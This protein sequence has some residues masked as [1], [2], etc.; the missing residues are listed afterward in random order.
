MEKFKNILK[1]IGSS[2]LALGMTF[3]AIPS[4]TVYG[5]EGNTGRPNTAVVYDA[6]SK[7]NLTMGSHTLQPHKIY[8]CPGSETHNHNGLNG[9][10][11]FNAVY[12]CPLK[13]EMFCIDINKGMPDNKLYKGSPKTP[14]EL[15][16]KVIEFL[17]EHYF[18]KDRTKAEEAFK[19]VGYVQ[20]A[21][22]GFKDKDHPNGN[23]TR[24]MYEATQMLI[25]E[26]GNGAQYESGASSKVKDLYDDIKLR[27][28]NALKTPNF[29]GNKGYNY[30]GNDTGEVELN[31]Y[32][33]E[34]AITLTDSEKVLH[35]FAEGG[36]P[37]IAVNNNKLHLEIEG[38]TCKVWTDKGYT[39]SSGVINVNSRYLYDNRSSAKSGFFY[40]GQDQ[41]QSLIFGGLDPT[42]FVI[43]VKM[44]LAGEA[45]VEKQDKETGEHPQ[46]DT[47]FKGAQFKLYFD[48]NCTD[49]VPN[50]PVIT[51]NEKGKPNK[52]WTELDRTKTYYVKEEKTPAG[53]LLNNEP[54]KLSFELVNG[55]YKASITIKDT[56]IKGKVQVHKY[57]LEEGSGIPVN[58]KGAEFTLYNK[59]NKKVASFTTNDK[60]IGVSPLLPYGSYTMKQTKAPF[61]TEIDTHTYSVVIKNK[62]QT[63]KLEPIV[64]IQQDYTL[65][66]V[67]KD[68]ETGALISYTGAKFQV[69]KDEGKPIDPTKDKP[70]SVKVGSRNY[71]TFITKNSTSASGTNAEFFGT[72]EEAGTVITPLKLQAGK[73]IL[74]EIEA[75][76]GFRD[77]SKET[78]SFIPFIVGEGLLTEDK[79]GNALITVEVKD[80]Q[81]KQRIA[82]KKTIEQKTNKVYDLS[83]IEYEIVARNDVVDFLTGA[84]IARAGEVVQT[85]KGELITSETQDKYKDI[86]IGNVPADKPTLL[87]VSDYLAEGEYTLRETKTCEGLVLDKTE[88]TITV[89]GS[90][91]ITGLSFIDDLNR[92]NCGMTKGAIPE[93]ITFVNNETETTFSKENVGGKEVVGAKMQVKDRTGIV[94]DEWT[95]TNRTHTVYG[96]TEGETYVLHEE[97]APTGMNLAQDIEFVVGQDNHIKMVDTM[98]F[99]GKVDSKTKKTI[100]GAT[101]V[102]KTRSGEILDIWK[103]EKE[104][105]IV[106]GLRAG[107]SYV[108]Q[109]VKAPKG[110]RK[111]EN[112]ITFTVSGDKD[113]VIQIMNTP[114]TYGT[115]HIGKV[116]SQNKNK[117]IKGAHLQVLDENGEVLSEWTS[118]GKVH[119]IKNL[120]TEKVY[121]IHEVK[122]PKGYEKGKDQDFRVK[123]GKIT[124]IKYENREYKIT[125]VG[126]NPMPMVLGGIALVVL[127]GLGG[128][129]VYRKVKKKNK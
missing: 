105:H 50:Q 97:L 120:D 32:G 36:K 49:P 121:T 127:L 38:N 119:V 110:Y 37:D 63:V 45:T 24:E 29:V 74:H 128:Y 116:D 25:W 99:I 22:Y 43:K 98:T 42:S 101:L 3:S 15:K 111:N 13:Q 31:G 109:E 54:V 60:G 115:V 84:V 83:Q 89:N 53:Y 67:K 57:R 91:G 117:N 9:Q 62:N 78:S 93:I 72:D 2:L 65:A 94:L 39:G 113:N 41:T 5:A 44:N 59:D 23:Y 75:P 70:L 73:Y 27:V 114:I 125:G 30:L 26:Y 124:T 100:A 18:N 96:L 81:I 33:K 66:I 8:F 51:V 52:S 76:K 104:P 107:E 20:A 112:P 19:K 106:K 108:L 28:E 95:S 1:K 21:G 129:E 34:N 55:K 47:T 7:L 17:Q 35:L 82:F 122:A 90:G 77:Y 126:A 88:H 92:V 86:V 16:E 123:V 69:Y 48:K 61:G 85:L 103:S 102:V 14:E 68:A 80:T 12:N 87:F 10:A 64:N 4:A 56:V 79:D 11:L 46:G 6:K 58:E 40:D 71:N 118:N